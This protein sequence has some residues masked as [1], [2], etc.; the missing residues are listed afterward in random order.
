M[1]AKAIVVLVAVFIAGVAAG[2]GLAPA[3]RPAHGGPPPLPVAELGLDADQE[4]K[5]RAVIAAH[6]AELDSILAEMRPRAQAVHRA[7]RAELDTILTAEQRTKLDELERERGG[8][9]TER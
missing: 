8:P 4:A 9:H 7:I 5:A 1:N 3:V 2:V 6:R